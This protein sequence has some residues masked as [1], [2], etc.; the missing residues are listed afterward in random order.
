MINA[1][2][3]NTSMIDLSRVEAGVRQ[4][5]L[6]PNFSLLKSVGSDS[7]IVGANEALLTGSHSL[8]TGHFTGRGVSLV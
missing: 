7:Q 8:L 1:S 2:M 3:I 5:E 4:V 6:H